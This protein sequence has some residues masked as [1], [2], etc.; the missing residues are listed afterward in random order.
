MAI[1]INWA[2]KVISIPKAD[3]T[4]VQSSPVEIRE[5]DLDS[6]RLEIFD[7]MDDEAGIVADTVLVN[8]PPL[9]ISGVTLARSVEIINGY[10][11]TFENLSYQVNIVGGNS[12]L[13]DRVNPNLVGVR[14][15][16]SAGLTFSEEINNQSYINATVYVDTT[17]A[18]TGTLFPLGTPPRPLNNLTDAHAV[19]DKLGYKRIEL[20]S[21]L[22]VVTAD[23]L[24]GRRYVGSTIEAAHV[25]LPTGTAADTTQTAFEYVHMDGKF[26]GRV[27]ISHSIVH[28]LLDFDGHLEDCR[29][30]GDITL[31]STATSSLRMVNCA[32]LV[33]GETKPTIDINGAVADINIRNY[34]GDITVKNVTQANDCA[35]NFNSGSITF[36]STCTSGAATVSGNVKV[37]DNSG[38][39]FTVDTTRTVDTLVA[40][41]DISGNT[42]ND[43]LGGHVKRGLKSAFWIGFRG[44]K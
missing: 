39:G 36:D 11:I 40:A 17:S 19:S 31:D 32:S 23:D 22:T 3:M 14:T 43:S 1:S 29:V 7:L 44:L 21:H 2:T 12:N 38:G 28:D 41:T 37:I 16:N 35:F 30:D 4:L 42:D 27:T 8:T 5:L 26:D 10:T 34:T 9:T 18:F 20:S 33:A 25:H 24:I 13:A 15:A 6:F